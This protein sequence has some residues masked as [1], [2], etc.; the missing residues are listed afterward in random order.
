MKGKKTIL[1]FLAIGLLFSLKA[2]SQTEYQTY[3]YPNGQISSE[4]TLR[5]GRLLMDRYR[6][7]EPCVMAV[8]MDF[9]RRIMRA[10]N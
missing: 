10:V 3:S 8:Q 7:K 6:A 4:G 5:D 9:G 2:F 1:L